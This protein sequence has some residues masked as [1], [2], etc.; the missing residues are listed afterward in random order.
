MLAESLRTSADF[1]AIPAARAL[2]GGEAL[3]L[4]LGTEVAKQTRDDGDRR[5]G[6]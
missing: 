2:P 4:A 5:A 3:G 6:T 1:C